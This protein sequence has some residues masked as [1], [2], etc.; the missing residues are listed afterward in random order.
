MKR[1]KPQ[2]VQACTMGAIILFGSIML[3]ALRGFLESLLGAV[4]IYVLFRNIMMHLCNIRQWKRSLTALL[5]ILSTF[6]I[7]LVP[8]II[9]SIMFIPK[10]NMFFDNASFIIHS[11]EN[12]SKQFETYTG[13]E[14][15]T[16]EN[17]KA[18]QAEATKVVSNILSSTIDIFGTHSHHV[19]YTL[20][21]ANTC[22]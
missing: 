20:F 22:R 18:L 9:A 14:V 3:Y 7:V 16:D 2:V 13:I 19:F 4:V 11:I 5:I 12:I 15:L 17:L 10:L 8:L 21:Y 1:V 6:L